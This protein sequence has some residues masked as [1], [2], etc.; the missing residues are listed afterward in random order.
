VPAYRAAAAFEPQE[1]QRSR[2][3]LSVFSLSG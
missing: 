1:T 3:H 2:Q